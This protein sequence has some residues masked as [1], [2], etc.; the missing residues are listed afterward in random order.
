MGQG[1]TVA[2]ALPATP[3]G[4][5]HEHYTPARDIIKAWVKNGVLEQ[6][7]YLSPVTHKMVSGLTVNNAKRPS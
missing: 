4:L 7:D 6:D 1:S 5:A 2:V 3:F